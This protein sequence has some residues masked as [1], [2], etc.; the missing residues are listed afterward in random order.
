MEFTAAPCSVEGAV[1]DVS[2]DSLP[3]QS[4]ELFL[5]PLHQFQ[6]PTPGSTPNIMLKVKGFKGLRF[7]A[8]VTG[9]LDQVITP[10]YDVI[11]EAERA[12]LAAQSPYNMVHLLLPQET[13]GSSAYENAKRSFQQWIETGALQQDEQPSLYLVRQHFTDLDGVAQVRRGFFAAVKLPEAGEKNILGHERT[14]SKPVEDRLHLT[15]ALEANP[16]AVFVMYSDPDHTLAP[17]L[18]QMEARDPDGVAHTMDGVKQEFW[19]VDHDNVVTEFFEDKILYIADGHHRFQTAGAYRDNQRAA[20]PDAG[21][22]PY[23]YVLMGFVDFAD[24]GLKIYPPHR[25]V[26]QPD[27]FSE[28]SFL[29]KLK[30]YFEVTTVETD[31]PALVA[32][33]EGN[34]VMGVSI[35]GGGDYL[36]TLKDIDRVALLGDDRSAPWREL[37]VAVLHRGILER[38]LEFPE[39]ST[40]T[41]EK[42]VDRAMAAA[43]SG[44]TGLAFILQAT[45]SS[46]IC[47]CAEAG[48][49]MPEK[50]TYFFPKLP[51]GGVINLLR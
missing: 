19:R 33:N 31:L 29:A 34:C 15:A 24:P 17:V 3:P 28:D 7:N 26:Q 37:D 30:Q 50:S 27:G 10:P 39:G 14:F 22:Q 4:L 49:P 46:Q 5:H 16:G 42:N 2:F 25:L 38:M 1:F 12:T 35:H 32:G 18:A 23:D 51:S 20:H 45:L 21:E 6:A 8:D 40:F 36:L 47:A 11:T 48:E 43:Q 44:E 13:E 41:Y 9:N